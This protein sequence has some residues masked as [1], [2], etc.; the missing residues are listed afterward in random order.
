MILV[1]RIELINN[2]IN[3]KKEDGILTKHNKKCKKVLGLQIEQ[4]PI[5]KKSTG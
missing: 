2:S 5:T 4:K 3:N 1:K